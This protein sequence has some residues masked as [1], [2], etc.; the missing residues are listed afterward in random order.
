MSKVMIVAHP[1][2]GA[3]I[4]ASKSNPEVGAIRVE[5]TQQVF[6]SKTGFFNEEKRTAFVPGKI[7]D[8]AKLNWE[9]GKTVTGKI[10]RLESFNPFYEGQ[11]MKRYP[12]SH[13]NAGEP[14]LTSG[15]PTYLRF[16]YTPNL[17]LQ[18]E[19]VDNSVGVE[20][21]EGIE[22]QAI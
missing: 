4:T 12:D 20:A 10:L 16:V 7:A 13:A 19:W 9:A 5:S 17:A 2:S 21:T 3:V 18:D 8:L 6:N 14:V 22:Q 15:R 11:D 1:E